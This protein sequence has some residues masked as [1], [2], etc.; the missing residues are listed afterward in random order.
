VRVRLTLTSRG[1]ARIRRAL[2][3]HM[4]V[5]AQVRLTAR[6]AAGNPATKTVW[7]RVTG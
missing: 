7:I 1:A 2:G 6:D 4:R 5:R 3:R